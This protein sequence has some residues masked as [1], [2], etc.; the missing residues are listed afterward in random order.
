MVEL[1]MLMRLCLEMVVAGV[2]WLAVTCWA[3]RFYC[4]CV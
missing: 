1:C 2:V 4:C 3:V